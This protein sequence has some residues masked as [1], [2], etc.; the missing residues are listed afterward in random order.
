MPSSWIIVGASSRNTGAA[1]VPPKRSLLSAGG[2][3]IDTR[4]VTCGSSAGR[5]P[6]KLA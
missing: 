4:M 1:A 5:K 2:W 6:T 3:S